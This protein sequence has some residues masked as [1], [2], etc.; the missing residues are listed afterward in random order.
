MQTTLR[1]VSMEES[2]ET[3]SGQRGSGTGGRFIKGR[4]TAVIRV[5]GHGLGAGHR[6]KRTQWAGTGSGALGPHGLRGLWG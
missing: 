6:E 5:T 3:G 4:C 1:G 2:R